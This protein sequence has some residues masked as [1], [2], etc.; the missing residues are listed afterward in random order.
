MLILFFI[1]D[2]GKFFESIRREV[3]IFIFVGF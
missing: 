2:V 1:L 3:S